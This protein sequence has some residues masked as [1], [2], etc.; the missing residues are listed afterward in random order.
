[1]WAFRLA[2]RSALKCPPEIM[3]EHRLYVVTIVAS[4]NDYKLGSYSMLAT[5]HIAL[6]I[7]LSA[8]SEFSINVT[9]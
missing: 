9:R 8:A 7:G 3:A 1:M 6:A 5:Q 4:P 2:A